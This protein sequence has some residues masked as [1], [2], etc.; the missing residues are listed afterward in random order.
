MA[1]GPSECNI[2][3]ICRV[4]PLN[5]SEEKAGSKFV[6][7]F[8][9]D[10]SIS[11]AVSNRFCVSILFTLLTTRFQNGDGPT[12]W[13]LNTI[14]ARVNSPRYGI[15]FHNSGSTL[16]GGGGVSPNPRNPNPR[17]R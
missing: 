15:G 4:R 14:Y 17:K 2:K 3:V 13:V 7:K 9:T 6:L 10:D 12:Y 8:P 5:E 1:D 11:I 16:K